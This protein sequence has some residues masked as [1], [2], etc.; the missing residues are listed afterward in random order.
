MAYRKD[1]H[2]QRR[3]LLSLLLPFAMSFQGRICMS[4]CS[5][6]IKPLAK[7]STGQLY[8]DH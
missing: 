7:I 8:Q 6:N 2:N 4:I 3:A 1:R 5:W